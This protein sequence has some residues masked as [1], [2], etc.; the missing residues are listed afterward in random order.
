MVTDSKKENTEEKKDNN[1]NLLEDE[2]NKKK[3]LFFYQVMKNR[4][5]FSDNSL[6]GLSK[7]EQQLPLLTWPFLDFVKTLDLMSNKLIELGSGNSTIFFSEVFKK[8]ETFE[9][10]KEWYEELS[11]QTKDNVFLNLTSLE[12]IENKLSKKYKFNNRDWLLVDFAGKRTRFINRLI[13][14]PDEDLPAQL[15]FDNSE[16]YNNARNLLDK[17][18]Y[19][20]IPF[21]GFKSG[22]N[23]ISCTSLFLL[24][25]KWNL[26]HPEHQA[27]PKYSTKLSR[28]GWDDID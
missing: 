18:G 23:F 19:T 1:P 20:E 7:N 2:I 27:Q 15:I 25:N 22:E 5:F 13:A 4:N 17:R 8:V 24:K 9:P 28:N 11:K 21:W 10:N 6:E 3:T 12:E 16:W 26:I 14:H